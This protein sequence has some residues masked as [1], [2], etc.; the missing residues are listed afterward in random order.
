V[1]HLEKESVDGVNQANISVA[2]GEAPPMVKN[3]R[4]K[5]WE[6]DHFFVCPLVGSCLSLSEQKQLLK[7]VNINV[8]EKSEFEMHE[9]IVACSDGENKLSRRVDRL[10]DRKYRRAVELLNRYEVD[11]FE[12]YWMNHFN[13]GDFGFMIWVAAIRP[14]LTFAGRKKMF[15]LI[16]MKMHKMAK[17]NASLKARLELEKEKCREAIER[18]DELA[19]VR[20]QLRIENTGL[21][22]LLEDAGRELA[23]GRLEVERL[24]EE[25]AAATDAALIAGY[26]KEKEHLGKSLEQMTIQVD[27]LKR[28]AKRL[29]EENVSLREE[30][31]FLRSSNECFKK[32]A[33]EFIQQ[34]A[35][36]QGC[37]DDCPNFDL[38]RK[39]V[40]IVGGITKMEALYRKIIEN[41]G[42]LFDYHTG[43]VRKGVKELEDRLKRADVVLCPVNCN[44]HTACNLVK[45]LA[46]KHSKPVQMLSGS[47]LS[48]V[49]QALRRECA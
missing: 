22:K 34:A 14:D 13:D 27:R 28:D 6:V 41:N 49:S 45:K 48:A 47:S 9:T 46:K 4:R 15:G 26:E 23:T 21:R 31:V 42:G 17:E 2:V 43:Y 33:R 35:Q 7:K 40:L 32:T 38:C 30:L 5:F 16:H 11:N 18:G 29:E 20:K 36:E 44:S 25:R 39:R 19:G 10:L 12:T 8:K 37:D 24:R 3:R 1:C